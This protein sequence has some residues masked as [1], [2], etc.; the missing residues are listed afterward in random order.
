MQCNPL[1]KCVFLIGWLVTHDFSLSAQSNLVHYGIEQ[2]LPSPETYFSHQDYDG[3]IWIC[4]DRGVARYN[5]YEFETFSV[6]DGL[7]HS[8]IFK[9]FEDVKHNLY[10][11]GYDGSI[12]YY[13]YKTKKFSAHWANQRI[14]NK[15][16]GDSWVSYIGFKED[17]L[18]AH[19][20]SHGQFETNFRMKILNRDSSF[21]VEHFTPPRIFD[22]DN[23]V[24]SSHDIKE[25][26]GITLYSDQL[27]SHGIAAVK[28]LHKNKDLL[29]MTSYFK[30]H[31]DQYKDFISIH[32]NTNEI[33]KAN[34]RGVWIYTLRDSMFY[35]LEGATD[36]KRD[37]E[38]NYW[39]STENNG[40]YKL[41]ATDFII[42]PKDKFLNKNDKLRSIAGNGNYLFLGTKK[43]AVYEYD[44][45]RG[46]MRELIQTPMVFSRF[47]DIS[48]IYSVGDRLYASPGC[49][50]YNDGVVNRVRYKTPIPKS[51]FEYSN[52]RIVCYS[53]S[54]VFL[55]PKKE[56]QNQGNLMY[57]NLYDLINER[58]LK[59]VNLKGSVKSMYVSPDMN[60]F[61]STAH[62]VYRIDSS[63]RIHDLSK[64][65]KLERATVRKIIGRGTD[66]LM[67]ATSGSGVIIV[68][69]KGQYII[70]SKQGILSDHV[71]D[72]IFGSD[73]SLWC[74][75]AQGI[76][77]IQ[78]RSG[79]FQ[80]F[81]VRN[82]SQE[83]GLGATFI[84]KLY[85]HE[86]VI[87]ALSEKGLIS[88]PEQIKLPKDP[89]PKVHLLSWKQGST[90]LPFKHQTFSFD[91][92][93]IE[94]NYLGI[95]FR[96]P[97]HQS[98][99]RYKVIKNEDYADWQYTNNRSVTLS[100]LAP[101][102]YVFLVTACNMDREWAPA[103]LCSFTINPHWTQQWWVRGLG[104]IAV[105]IIIFCLYILDRSRRDRR[106]EEKIALSE[107]REKLN[108][109]ELDV[110]RGQ[111]N[112]HF[113][114]NSL[115]SVQKFLFKDNKLEANQFISRLARLL[116][117]GLE[118]SREDYIS[119]D[120][121]IR[122]IDNYM[123]VE[124]Q[125][126]PDRFTYALKV[127][128]LLDQSIKLPPLMVQ[129]LCE[130]AIK[131]A[132]DKQRVHI[133]IQFFYLS[134]DLIRIV[135]EDNGIG[136][137]NKKKTETTVKKSLGH[138]ILSKRIDIFKEK[139]PKASF[140]IRALNED[141]KEGTLAELILPIV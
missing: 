35:P 45:E 81:K 61:A 22:Y 13:D 137:F 91:E 103:A 37:R 80:D 117:T 53:E 110:L 47:S 7:T 90:E 63:F 78:F 42:Y 14:K 30:K 129:S 111:M 124:T 134:E 66:T 29:S 24:F 94:I 55:C 50:I 135:V 93:N 122:F 82:F 74:A 118:Y 31:S 114:Y 33:L 8:T 77:H 5:G 85:L 27:L 9:V 1:I 138:E 32:L 132:Y 115:N 60:I 108:A 57:L 25:L 84:S 28:P 38:G 36:A 15:I 105:A 96:K 102:D 19:V 69:G 41:A 86:G 44:I 95:T 89:L 97:K 73:G 104:S 88:F 68:H 101:G 76:S 141:T 120:K 133:R 56:K 140:Q 58:I 71:N 54:M 65:Y 26:F 109:T 52:D 70:T 6:R 131:H 79:N 51:V 46:G 121:E 98:F 59:K 107:L 11:T 40:M 4:T 67:L 83:N 12:T 113:I 49:E 136:I 126:F 127:D 139:N 17:T 112:P 116:R 130:N 48:E 20:T 43:G 62:A 3:Y 10:F 23:L 39:F 128:E 18:Y 34:R 100:Q 99:Y 72:I 2:G 106:Y 64:K 75:T 92:N 87:Y 21:L 16:K 119:L 125:R 123:K